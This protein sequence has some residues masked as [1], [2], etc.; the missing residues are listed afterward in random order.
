[1]ILRKPLFITFGIA[2]ILS[3]VSG[4][5]KMTGKDVS[6]KSSTENQSTEEK[7][8][9]ADRSDKSQE[10]QAEEESSA[11]HQPIDKTE[12]SKETIKVILGV[13]YQAVKNLSFEKRDKFLEWAQARADKLDESV[14]ALGDRVEKLGDRARSRWNADV[15]PALEERQAKLKE[16]LTAIKKSSKSAWPELKEK[17]VD[18]ADQL[19][20]RVKNALEGDVEKLDKKTDDKEST[21][22]KNLTGD[23][24]ET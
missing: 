14:K 2:V 18:A 10:P 8:S 7:P 13:T 19:E 9:L 15:K 3:L 12:L 21:G 24:D 23:N 6:D 22:E 16:R 11:S 1:M 4:C 5:T 20:E 17:F